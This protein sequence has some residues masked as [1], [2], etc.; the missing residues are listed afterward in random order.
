MLRWQLSTPILAA[1]PYIL[2]AYNIN[3]F[4]V[5]AIIA[6]LIGSLIFFKVDELIFSKE[7]SRF[8]KLRKCV[9]KKQSKKIK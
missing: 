4:I 1:I 8:Q 3:N 7:V 9:I 6:N 2:S 5:T